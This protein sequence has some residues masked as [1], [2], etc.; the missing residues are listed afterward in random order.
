MVDEL[1]RTRERLVMSEKMASW[2]TIARKV[3][4]EI[5]NPLTPISLIADQLRSLPDMPK[6]KLHSILQQSAKVIEEETG[7]LQRMVREFS[8]FASLPRPEPKRE[9]LTIV[10]EDFIERNT[11]SGGPE[12]VFEKRPGNYMCSVDRGMMFQVLHN[13]SNNARLAKHPE[14]VTVRVAL[15]AA[16]G[17]IYAEVSDNGPGIPEAMRHVLFEAY[18]TTR[19]TGDAEKGMGLGLAISRKILMDHDG[20]LNLK[21][22]SPSGACFEFR[23][24]QMK[25]VSRI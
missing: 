5:K 18:T 17:F 7:S 14:T 21:G 6:E 19:S 22:T 3:A 12:F 15:R 24:P 8:G 4:H 11:R 9:D 2:Q 16:D 13:L 10:V 23:V 1:G 25:E 20:Y